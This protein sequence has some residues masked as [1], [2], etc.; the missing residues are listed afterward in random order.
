MEFKL[1]PA[2][3]KLEG[4]VRGPNVTPGYWRQPQLSDAARDEEGFYKLGDAFKFAD[5]DNPSEGLLFDGR[6]AED[7]KLATG[8]W[9]NVGPL[10]VHIIDHFAPFVR[11]VVISGPNRDEIGVLVFPDVEACRRLVPHLPANAPAAMLLRD[12][13]VRGEFAFLLDTFAKQSTGSS[14]RVCRAILMHEQPSLDLGEIT[15]KGSINQ[16]MVLGNRAALVDELHAE[17]PSSRVI[18]TSAGEQEVR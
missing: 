18:F 8:T 10:R 9:V 7:F 4:R 17:P 6:T 5:P 1:V 12:A 11:D 15:D 16:G 13:Q 14:N 2:E 3:A